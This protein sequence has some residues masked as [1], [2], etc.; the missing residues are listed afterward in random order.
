[1]NEKIGSLIGILVVV[2]LF[3]LIS[4]LVKS[5]VETVEKFVINKEIGIGV[6]I[7]IQVVSVVV[8]P[9]SSIFLVPLASNVWGWQVV[10]LI[11]ILSWSLGAL[12]S[13][14]LARRYGIKLV[15]RL[16][17]LKKFYKIEKRIPKRDRFLT[18][19]F[20]RVVLPVDVLSYA[21]GLFSK[22]DTKT[23][24][25]ATIMGIIPFAIIY[26]I[27]GVL[28]IKYQIIIWIVAGIALLIGLYI[29]GYKKISSA[30]R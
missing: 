5:N 16:V 15:R 2:S 20:L 9:L 27:L 3:I 29:I 4:L 28:P 10:S 7:V 25:L 22:V 18:I 14:L 1:M 23:Y 24:M 19:V 13:F 30:S 8:A 21:L 12:I 11:N 17:P 6:Y 26:S